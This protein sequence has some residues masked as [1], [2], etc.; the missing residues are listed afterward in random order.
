MTLHEIL[1]FRIEISVF[2]YD[3]MVSKHSYIYTINEFWLKQNLL[4][5]ASVHKNIYG[6]H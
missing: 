3:I 1:I 6:A 4:S 2:P 5:F